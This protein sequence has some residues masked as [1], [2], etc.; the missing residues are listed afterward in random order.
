ME[1]A[2]T[3]VVKSILRFLHTEIESSKL[4]MEQKESLEVAKQCLE[5]TYEIDAGD[6]SVLSDA[7][8]L[9]T[10]FNVASGVRQTIYFISNN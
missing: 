7:L 8:N 10:L 6:P 4:D 2:K 1:S 3:D 9:Y 5:S